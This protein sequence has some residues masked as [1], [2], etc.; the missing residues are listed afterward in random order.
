VQT[1]PSRAQT[2]RP[3]NLQYSSSRDNQ[4]TLQAELPQQGTPSKV[5][6]TES[7][8]DSTG[9]A[10]SVWDE[11]D[12]LKSRIRR[13]ELGGKIPT[14]S[15]AVVAN[16]TAE[17]PRTAN[18]SITTVS[19]SPKQQRKTN[20]SPPGSTI[21]AQNSNKAHPVLREALTKVKQYVT[22]AVYRVLEATSSEAIALAEM[23]GSAGPQGTLHSASLLLNGASDRQVRRKADSLCRSLTELCIELCDT[24][25]SAASPALRTVAAS[26]M[27]R[28]SVQLNGESP[29]IRQSIE[30]EEPPRNSPSRAMDRIQARRTSMFSSGINGGPRDS[31]QE[32]L[33]PSQSDIPT[34]VSRAGTSLLRARRT[35]EN[36]DDDEPIMRAPSRALTDFRDLR[37]ANPTSRFTREY[38]SREPMPDLQPSPALQTHTTS[39]RRP[40]VTGTG[41][42][43]LLYRPNGQ[44]YTLDR[45]SS[46]A[47]EKQVSADLGPRSQYNSNTQYNTNRNSTGGATNLGRT[48]SLGG[49]RLRGTGAGE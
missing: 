7:L 43:N 15:G 42:E 48:A 27:R 26:N 45:Q 32:P 31:S 3:S 4:E 1:P 28:P 24:K 12:D 18:T 36:D 41:N 29:T 49:R 17:R 39:L 25:S 14:T 47:Y 33:A 44:R 16:A 19:S 10:A 37:A 13:I 35:G 11:L 46:P 40:T 5:D 38:T 30:I 9:P 34:R 8:D 6:G 20:T 22:P 2:F 21:S 23:T